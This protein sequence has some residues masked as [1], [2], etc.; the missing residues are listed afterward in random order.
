MA[1]SE[2]EF[3]SPRLVYWQNPD[4]LG[5]MPFSHSIQDLS[6]GAHGGDSTIQEISLASVHFP[7]NTIDTSLSCL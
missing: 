6:A 2:T 5:Q 3:G 4:S 1:Q 7:P